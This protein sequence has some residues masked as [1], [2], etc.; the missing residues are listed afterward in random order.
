MFRILHNASKDFSYGTYYHP[1]LF[2]RL[3]AWY[4]DEFYIQAARIVLATLSGTHGTL[5]SIDLKEA[6]SSTVILQ[7]E[8]VE[9]RVPDFSVVTDSDD[10][11]DDTVDDD[12][13]DESNNNDT[14]DDGDNFAAV[15]VRR[16]VVDDYVCADDT[17][18]PIHIF[19]E[20]SANTTTTGPNEFVPSDDSLLNGS[21]DIFLEEPVKIRPPKF[22]GEM[23]FSPNDEASNCSHVSENETIGQR[24]RDRVKEIKVRARQHEQTLLELSKCEKMEYERQLDAERSKRKILNELLETARTER[25]NLEDQVEALRCEIEDLKLQHRGAVNVM[26]KRPRLDSVIDL[27]EAKGLQ[28][29]EFVVVV[30]FQN[31]DI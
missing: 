24:Y 16:R 3:V 29:I 8:I 7:P 12:T 20:T 11:S 25:E 6:G 15:T 9:N 31:G 4:S 13:I 17:D 10:D 14:I 18:K 28:K 21:H 5:K 1:I 19:Q 26:R 27:Y 2:S 23:P 22:M 30:R